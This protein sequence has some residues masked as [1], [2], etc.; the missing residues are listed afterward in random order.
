MAS[1]FFN[2]LGETIVE[3]FKEPQDGI[4]QCQPIEVIFESSHQDIDI[5]GRPY[6][7]PKPVAWFKTGMIS[8]VYG[9]IITIAAKDYTIVEIKVDGISQVTE[10]ILQEA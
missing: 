7:A 2:R 3:I 1:R 4:F 5:N 8:P 6:G 9:D 10:L